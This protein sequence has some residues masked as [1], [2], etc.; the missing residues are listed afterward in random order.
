ME[1]KIY[2]ELKEKNSKNPFL[3][4]DENAEPTCCPEDLAIIIKAADFAARRHRAQRRHDPA[5]SPF[6]N[7]CIGDYL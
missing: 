3:N 5:R 4:N 6:I 1:T 7:H 2:P